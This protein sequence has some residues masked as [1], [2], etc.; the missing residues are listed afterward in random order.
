MLNTLQV[1]DTSYAGQTSPDLLDRGFRLA[2]FI[3]PDRAI[4]LQILRNAMSK[5]KVHRTREEKRIYWRDKNLKRK[6]TKTVRTNVDAL[7]WLIYCESTFYEKEQEQSAEP[8]MSDMV[9]FYVN[10]GQQR[11]LHTYR[12]A[13]TQ[14]YYEYITGHCP[15]TAEYRRIKRVLMKQLEER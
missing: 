15:G 12:T 6:I 4:A 7:Q 5:L 13:D 14:K 8:T 9:V 2:L 10:V 1:H 11:I 3:F